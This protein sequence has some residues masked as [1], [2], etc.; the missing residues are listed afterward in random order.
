MI[1]AIGEEAGIASEKV[2]GLLY[3]PSSDTFNFNVVLRFKNNSKEIEV[4]TLDQLMQ[5]LSELVLNRRMLTSNIARIFDPIGFLCA[6]LLQAKLLMREM[7]AEKDIGWDDPISDE[8]SQ[9]WIKFLSSLLKLSN[10]KFPRSLWPDGEVEG[11]PM[12]IVFSDGSALAFGAVAYIRWKLAAGGYWTR[13]IMAKCEIAPK[14]FSP[15]LEWNSTVLFLVT[16]LKTL[17]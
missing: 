11:L 7:W 13:I 12:L 15:F 2:L 14:T 8:L 10:I 6:I 4:T 9:K 3:N 5:V 16:E 1:I 17:F